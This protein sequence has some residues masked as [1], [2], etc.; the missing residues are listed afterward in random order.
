VTGMKPASEQVPHAVLLV[1]HG[2]LFAGCGNDTAIEL[3]EVQPEGKKR[4]PASDF[5][6]GYRPHEGAR[7]GG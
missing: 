4:M 6:R 2:Q 5:V 3:L 7:I 1:R